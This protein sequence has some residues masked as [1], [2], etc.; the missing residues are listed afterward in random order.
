MKLSENTTFALS[1]GFAAL[2]FLVVMGIAYLVS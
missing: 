2:V 1:I